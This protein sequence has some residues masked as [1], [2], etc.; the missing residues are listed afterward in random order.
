MTHDTGTIHDVLADINELSRNLTDR[1]KLR[2]GFPIFKELV[3]NADDANAELLR[4]S[5]HQ[6]FPQS[7]HRLLAGP[8]M[9]VLND[10]ATCHQ[11]IFNI[12]RL[13]MNY[14]AGERGAIGKF[15]LGLKSIFHLCEAFFYLAYDP[16]SDDPE[17]AQEPKVF[18]YNPWN[19]GSDE[20]RFHSEWDL[21]HP[22]HVASLGQAV[23]PLRPKGR[24]FAL[25]VPLRQHCHASDPIIRQFFGEKNNA[26]AGY[27]P[28]HLI[29]R[30][31]RVLP[32]LSS[33]KRVEVW[34]SA[35]NR[36]EAFAEI[37]AESERR[38]RDIDSVNEKPHHF[39]GKIR[40][41]SLIPARESNVSYFGVE[42]KLPPSSVATIANSDF[43]PWT[44]SRTLT[45]ESRTAK[46]PA[47]AHAAA[48]LVATNEAPSRLV[49]RHACYLPLASS[50]EG[51]A[52]RL[53]SHEIFLHGRFFIDAGRQAIPGL[54][55]DQLPG[56][57]SNDEQ[58]R[59]VWNRRL[60]EQGSLPLL[61]KAIAKWSQSLSLGDSQIEQI[62]RQIENDP[63]QLQWVGA[64]CR[65]EQW[66]YLL[67]PPTESNRALGNWTLKTA[68]SEVHDIPRPAAS[69]SFFDLLPGIADVCSDRALTFAGWP[70]ITAN[71]A[72]R[73]SSTVLRKVVG[74]VVPTVLFMS[75]E[76][77]DYFARFLEHCVDSEDQNRAV[78]EALW[79]LL[80]RA[81]QDD[82][83][84]LQRIEELGDALRRVLAFV[85]EEHRLVL[86]WASSKRP[87]ADAVF[88][89]IAKDE[90]DLLP[91]PSSV[92]PT[93][94]RNCETIESRVVARVLRTIED[95]PLD[96]TLLADVVGDLFNRADLDR[97]TL[98]QS[99]KDVRLLVVYNCGRKQV[100][101]KTWQD[102]QTQ[103]RLL[104][105][106]KAGLTHQLQAALGTESEVWRIDP[107][108]ATQVLGEKHGLPGCSVHECAA[109][110]APSKYGNATPLP[111]L[112]DWEA[113][114]ELL[115]KL[116]VSIG[117]GTT[118]DQEKMKDACRLM[119]HGRPQD[120]DFNRALFLAAEGH[121]DPLAEKL[122]RHVLAM[123]H[124]EWR[125]L[126]G[127]QAAWAVED[128][129]TTSQ[130]K[131]LDFYPLILSEPAVLDLLEKA[132]T[133]HLIGIDLSKDEY[134][135]LLTDIDA[136]R[137]E[138]LK[139][140]PIHPVS[141]GK[142]RIAIQSDDPQRIFWDGGYE[143]DAD[144][145]ES[146]TLLA[147]DKRDKRVAD[148]QRELAP[149]LD[150]DQA[151]RLALH[152]PQPEKHW[153]D[154]LKAIE[155]S[156]ERLPDDIIADLRSKKW[157]PSRFGARSRD[158][159][160]C[161]TLTGHSEPSKLPEEFKKEV[162]RLV[163]ANNGAWIADWMLA[164]KLLKELTRGSQTACQ[165]LV[166][167]G[168]LPNETE[169]LQQLGYLIGEDKQ[170]H[171]GYVPF[172]LFQD[173]LDI[174]WDSAVM[175]CHQLLR[176]MRECL[177]IERT[178]D[179]GAAE[180]RVPIAD[181]ER[182]V[183]IMN[184][185]GMHHNQA[186]TRDTKDRAV[187]VF[188]RYFEFL[189]N[190]QEFESTSQLAPVQLLSRAG[191]WES[192][193]E[194]CLPTDGIAAKHILSDD[195]AELLEPWC[196]QASKAS[197]AS[198]AQPLPPASV[199]EQL[200]ATAQSSAIQLE[201]YFR[202]WES[203]VPH[204]VIGGFVSLLGGDPAVEQLASRYL[205]KRSLDETR[206]NLRVSPSPFGK[207][208][209]RMPDVAFEI[210]IVHG[211]SELMTNLL[212]QQFR[213]ALTDG[214][215]GVLVGWGDGRNFD[216]QK[217][218]S[219]WC[220]G[221]RLRAVDFSATN[222]NSIDASQ[223]LSHAAALLLD[224]VFVIQQHSIPNL[225]NETFADLQASDQL[226]IRVTQQLILE[227]AELLLSQLGLHAD[228]LL[229]PVISNQT[230]F[231]R[232]RAERSHNQELFGRAAS[233]TE[234]EI[235]E[236]QN[237]ANRNLRRLLEDESSGGPPRVLSAVC[238][239]IQG[240]NQY[241]PMAVPFE[242]FQNADDAAVERTQL[243]QSNFSA[244]C[245]DYFVGPNALVVRHFGRC[246]NQVPAGCDPRDHKLADDLRKMLTLWLSNK[247]APSADRESVE[248][249][250]KFGL[251]FKSV[252][253]VS[254]KPQ[255]LSG[256]IGCEIIGGVFPRYLD[257]EQRRRFDRF[258]HDLTDERK[259]E[260][261]VIELP[262]RDPVV[263]NG[264]G[265]IVGRFRE[266]AHLLVV[267]ARQIRFIQLTD[268][269]IG[270]TH[271]TS[272]QDL[273]ISGLANWFKGTLR[274]LPV[275]P[276]EVAHA[277]IL[278]T[279]NVSAHRALVLRT[280]QHSGALLLV[281]DGKR[282]KKLAKEV[283][284]LW[285]TAPTSEALDV[286]FA[287]N[288][289]FSLDPGRAQ[290]G[291][292][293]P[294][295]DDIAADLGRELGQRFAALF[296]FRGKVTWEQFCESLG[297]DG[298]ADE[299]EFW[300][301]LWE[302]LGPGLMRLSESSNAAQLVLRILWDTAEGAL[303]FYRNHVAIPSNL[304]GTTDERRLVALR[305][306]RFAVDGVLAEGDGLELMCVRSWPEFKERLGLG[307]LV[308]HQFV[309][310]PLRKLC[311]PLAANIKTISLADVLDWEIPN[312][313]VDPDSAS[314]LGEVIHKDL[315]LD[316]C[317]RD[318]RQ[319]LQEILSE[320][321]FLN[322]LGDSIEP[323]RLMIGHLPS[324]APNSPH[325]DERARAVFAPK[326]R[327]LNS[328]YD[329]AG[330]AFFEVCRAR[331]NATASEMAQWVFE[332]NDEATRQA[333][334][335][336]LAEGEQG[337]AI[338]KEINRVG[339]GGTWLETLADSKEFQSMEPA[340]QGRLLEI[341]PEQRAVAVVTRATSPQSATPSANQV[342]RVLEEIYKWWSNERGPHL[343]KYEQR[344]FPE[345]GLRYLNRASNP[346]EE[347]FRKDWVTLFLLGLTHT[348]GRT[349][350]EQHR[351][352][353]RK[354]ERDGM[355]RMI[356]SSE[357]EPAA[358]MGW[359]DDF[360]YRQI[361]DSPY[362]Q[363]MKQFVGIYQVSRHLKDY[364][365]AFEAV[366]SDDF[367]SRSFGLAEITSL[368]T[369]Y[370]FS[371]S[372]FDA[373]PLSRVLGMGQCFVLRELVRKGVLTNS[374]AFRH[375][376]VPTKRVRDLLAFG[377]GC[378]G[379][380]Q[381]SCKWELSE[382]IYKFLA[383]RL[384]PER[385]WFH[386]CF[387]LPFQI[388]AENEGLQDRF[389]NKTLRFE[390]DE[391]DLWGPGEMSATTDT[392]ES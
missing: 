277:E 83:L 91:I 169:S 363:W 312:R 54:D 225:V 121:V 93:T 201:D 101:R 238:Q 368:R 14:K 335:W 237:E 26:R 194:L 140:L 190:H 41:V 134:T 261:T 19:G 104:F 87:G 207:H 350:A 381:Q 283:P 309:I 53:S 227:D 192:P 292:E 110:L 68:R 250:G 234:D 276:L 246:V 45:G 39:R 240:H 70:R 17:V 66:L 310:G 99:L 245:I 123:R 294:E 131:S 299:Y 151:L 266:M 74:S 200:A 268:D 325:Q 122:V 314:R 373:P 376:Y 184:S 219:K 120:A 258:I 384:G 253:L 322:R 290:L 65:D 143:L 202:P 29:D 254:D 46:A 344:T 112:G 171:I 117:K 152:S 37:E 221:I 244:N 42:L 317:H 161:L 239:R 157:F 94:G 354:C 96:N 76:Y 156:E 158:D 362:L 392:A 307:A 274:P 137:N 357:R 378:E 20:N 205:G 75:S 81:F 346:D 311:P 364:I 97:E 216:V 181:S 78:G 208:H 305:D 16:N 162:T 2:D 372:D 36:P 95:V 263:E 343:L 52:A 164:E 199:V 304:P 319:R 349:V 249:T 146:I 43:W 259:R 300:N 197:V 383:D 180:V 331:L 301:S 296:E 32:M 127:E 71:H 153:R 142:Q 107:E 390:D 324:G 72:T 327:V 102:L 35:G 280:S 30:I 21:I 57:P 63:V 178:F 265:A 73:W 336:Y 224:E 195:L 285:V 367:K 109:V 204:D 345:G 105:C 114:K 316:Q 166:E 278:G 85:P 315:L 328:D 236:E 154:I 203:H 31:A 77:L 288:A 7:S 241:N 15:G 58:V 247:D 235:D 177:G 330:I 47:D 129:L 98:W 223:L 5:W 275:V 160:I 347:L 144:L 386:Y 12:R 185:L 281:H 183:G 188:R 89:L 232:L 365:G 379:L 333:A 198:W 213:A 49:I 342:Q 167:W 173:W 371:G 210:S 348:M 255:L 271:E 176:V 391:S 1:Y 163:E 34:N 189:L 272:W 215:D 359:A 22:E 273:P 113:R 206:R 360:L 55:R 11:D 340:Q 174:E 341:I 186:Q 147:L 13:G 298:R 242:L 106:D 23:A 90:C 369:S 8:G 25:W 111:G 226:E 116:T 334:L 59:E 69:I 279:D 155:E 251:G 338:Q 100:S 352:F 231:R 329:P 358:W 355:L 318:E 6:G 295:N 291:R 389:F 267:F 262:L 92:K 302:L 212:G 136:S 248:L 321:R 60:F 51:D 141:K 366:D 374:R 387:D 24:F 38:H 62:T 370:R 337:R 220:I 306:V 252:F 233:W 4:I 115:T 191:T 125:I 385:A 320:V 88:H 282:F 380:G 353:I 48:V 308:S 313:Q 229:G 64:I 135:K 170:H 377:L 61:L 361:Q 260:V 218:G 33:L 124:E 86:S 145:T 286:G 50:D 130:Q 289:R 217:K 209:I 388:I 284:T 139:R 82:S 303:R 149:V 159:L 287:L 356:A 150:R 222:N 351:D 108:F 10:G 80:K 382:H 211:D 193:E 132:K 175:P 196:G 264:A 243:L 18:I 44:R 269:E 168:V 40:V 187:R 375:C 270:K 119:I 128:G 256:R 3:Q 179:P 118:D 27:L 257:L 323:D 126:K 165:R 79:P 297:L 339:I 172:D 9:L 138:L 67:K 84:T 332:A 56:E 326:S 28:N 103:K 230:R 182:L 148:R 133:D 214:N 228:E 293:S